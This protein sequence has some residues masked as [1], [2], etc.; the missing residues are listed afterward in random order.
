[1][2]FSCPQSIGLQSAVTRYESVSVVQ[3]HDLLAAV[4][5]FTTKRGV[6]P[7]LTLQ[8]R[9]YT[10]SCSARPR[11]RVSPDSS[12]VSAPV[13]FRISVLS[14]IRVILVQHWNICSTSFASPDPPADTFNSHVLHKFLGSP[15]IVIV[16]RCRTS[17]TLRYRDRSL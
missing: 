13:A 14:G 6:C 17:R 4:S 11:V 10:L 5:C 15:K 8:R 7:V 3:F 12:P 9:T 1:M 16:M 2:S